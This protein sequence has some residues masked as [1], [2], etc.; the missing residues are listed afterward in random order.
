M[1]IIK[2][3]QLDENEN[4]EEFEKE[5]KENFHNDKNRIKY[6]INGIMSIIA[7]TIHTFGYFSIY[8]L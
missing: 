1:R 2:Y 3:K 8:I 7:C 4:Y 6:I 5:D